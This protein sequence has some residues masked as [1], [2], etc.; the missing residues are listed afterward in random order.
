MIISRNE[1][2]Q[3]FL[4]PLQKI[5][6]QVTL[7]LRENKIEAIVSSEDNTLIAFFE[8]SCVNELTANVCLPSVSKLITALELIDNDNIE[9]VLNQNSL[10]HKATP[11]FK[12]HL[13]DENY[14]K[15]SKLN[16]DKIKKFTYD[17]T[18]S[19]TKAVLQQLIKASQFAADTNKLYLVVDNKTV[20]G[21]LTDKTK[22]CDSIQIPITNE[23]T[24][25]AL[26]KEFPINF[27]NIRSLSVKH[28]NII[29]G[30]NTAQ[31]IISFDISKAQDKMLYIVTAFTK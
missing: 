12:Y 5:S 17:V 28:D 21:E 11:K 23:I 22:E 2:L 29:V 20:Y 16:S 30:I 9:L 31:S 8:F 25:T 26:H 7:S 19:L 10:E 15:T 3:D 18:F 6:N 14:S 24:G 27:E 4:K 13:F 1:F